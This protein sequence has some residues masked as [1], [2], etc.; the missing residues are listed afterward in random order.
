MRCG[1]VLRARRKVL[2]GSGLRWVCPAGFR[3]G[4]RGAAP[5]AQ[6]TGG[7]AGRQY[8]T[9]QGAGA[10]VARHDASPTPG[11]LPGK[12]S[13]TPRPPPP[14]NC[15]GRGGEGQR[16]PDGRVD[17]FLRAPEFSPSPRGTRGEGAGGWGPL[18]PPARSPSPPPIRSQEAARPASST[19]LLPPPRNS[20]RNPNIRWRKCLQSLVD[21][22][23]SLCAP[24]VRSLRA[25]PDRSTRRAGKARAG[26]SAYSG[27]VRTLS[28]KAL[29]PTRF[30]RI[31]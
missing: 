5:G 6:G 21:D 25:L 1:W 15:A 27:P 26:V 3:T 11:L 8:R 24:A 10:S 22:D 20:P 18:R 19:L 16:H 31:A 4:L 28:A 14:A 7:A 9:F 2:R 17:T 12:L 29:L 13:P 30:H 23:R